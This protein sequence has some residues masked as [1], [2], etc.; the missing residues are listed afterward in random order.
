M[1]ATG[2]AVVCVLG[3]GCGGTGAA[4]EPAGASAATQPEAKVAA[5]AEVAKAEAPAVAKPDAKPAAPAGPVVTDPTF[6]L[7]L[8]PAGKYTVG[9]LG[10]VDL[11]L[12]PRGI[13]HINQEY[14]ISIEVSGGDGVT[15]PKAKLARTDAAEFGQNK[16]V[17]EVPLT[18]KAAGEQKLQAHVRFAVCTEE[19]CVPDER[20][21]ALA[22][23]VE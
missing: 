15:L 19:T 6:E 12:E 17:F 9:E 18:P 14:P 16:A 13:Y 2:I 3:M 22:L 1:R 20:T 10:R 8:A 11:S 4:P 5:K 23:A 21:L 7:R